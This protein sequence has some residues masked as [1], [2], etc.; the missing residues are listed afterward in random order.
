V[1]GEL[2]NSTRARLMPNDVMPDNYGDRNGSAAGTGAGAAAGGA[3]AFNDDDEETIRDNGSEA[4][5]SLWGGRGMWLTK[6][7]EGVGRDRR[8][9]FCLV[10]RS[11]GSVFPSSLFPFI[12]SYLE[13]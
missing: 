5:E 8:R 3:T 1:W 6:K 7:G 11:E 10:R 9:Y 12:N 13:L 4:E 2:L